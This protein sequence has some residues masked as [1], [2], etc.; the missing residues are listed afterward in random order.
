VIEKDQRV[1][2]DVVLLRTSDKSGRCFIRTDQLDGETDWKLR[3]PI[4]QDCENDFELFSQKVTIYAERP[5]M[6]IHSFIGTLIK[7]CG[8]SYAHQK[9]MKSDTTSKTFFL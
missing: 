4:L 9:C 8:K 2:A 3:L 5:Q 7:V 6:D 1:P